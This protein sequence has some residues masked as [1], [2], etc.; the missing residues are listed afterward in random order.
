[1]KKNSKHFASVHQARQFAVEID[2]TNWSVEMRKVNSANKTY[3]SGWVVTWGAP[4]IG[5]AK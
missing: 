3:S 5:G 2:K 4:R 1:M